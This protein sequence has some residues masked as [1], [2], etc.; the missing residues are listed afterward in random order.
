MYDHHHT[1]LTSAAVMVIFC[2]FGGGSGSGRGGVN[3][4][5]VGGV[6][7]SE[8]VAGPKVVA[9]SNCVRAISTPTD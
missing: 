8:G 1:L 3:L 9:A 2:F 6:H 4:S 5:A 7:P